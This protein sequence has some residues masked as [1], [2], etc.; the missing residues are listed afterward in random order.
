MRFALP[1]LSPRLTQGVKLGLQRSLIAGGTLAYLGGMAILGLFAH[2]SGDLPDPARLWEQNRPPSIQ[3][4]DRQGRDLVVRGA[5]AQAPTP[6]TSLPPHMRQAVLATEDR[7]F[8]AHSGVDP[9]GLARA[10]YRN[11]RAG[12]V[13]EGGSTLTQQLTKNVFLTPDQTLTRKAQEMMLAVWLE[14][15]FSKDELLRLY[16]SRVY[17]GGGAWGLEAASDLYFGR[18]P[19]ELTLSEAAMLAGLLKA[20]SAL[21]PVDHP[22]RAAARMRTVLRGMDRR[23]LLD[24]GVLETALTA[25]VSVYRPRRNDPAEYI[26]DWIWPELERQIG[27]PNRDLIVQLSVDALLQQLA[28]AAVN[29]HLDPDRG[30]SQGA[31]VLLGGD[32]AIL[33]MVGGRDYQISQFNRA[34]TMQRQPGSSFKPVVY[35]AAIRAGMSPWAEEIDSSITIGDWTPENFGGDT[36]NKRWRLEDAMAESL[37]TVAV[38][39]SESIGAEA[40]VETAATLGLNDLSPL[41]SLALGAQGVGMIDLARAY[42]PFGTM[43]YQAEPHALL[44]IATAD[45]TPLYDRT[46][47]EERR[48]LNPSELRLMNRMLVRSVEQGT[49]R[50]ARISGRDIGGKTGTTNDNRDAWFVGVAPDL[51]LAVWVGDDDNQ[52]MRG[53]TGGTI[54]ARIFAD[55]MGAALEDRPRATLPQAPEPDWAIRQA[56][57]NSLLDTLE[58]AVPPAQAPA[59]ASPA[60]SPA[61]SP[62]PDQRQ[63]P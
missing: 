44:S 1:T 34:T 59:P 16:L 39:V 7:R 41:P 9:Y 28:H 10:A 51:S 15:R 21:Y 31:L 58:A 42:Q 63:R 37:N 29:T 4:I 6:I 5:Q 36:S 17:F 3:I 23:G 38:R 35:L 54:P 48:V 12:R 19:T 20:P 61:A 60:A 49:G 50:A 32:G 30:A 33:A 18:P 2:L 8:Y 47:T 40:V 25:P 45:G 55:V 13:V 14:R 26:V 22:D 56:E 11:L 53:V 24:D 27:V 62:Q 43:G 46:P 52:P 57:F